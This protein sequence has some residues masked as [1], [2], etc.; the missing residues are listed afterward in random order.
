LEV[1]VLQLSI[2]DPLGAQSLA[3]HKIDELSAKL[4]DNEHLEKKI[5]SLEAS[6]QLIVEGLEILQQQVAKNAE[7]LFQRTSTVESPEKRRKKMKKSVKG[8]GER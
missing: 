2:V 6:I 3:L 5:Q 4:G 8:G 1:N 7:P